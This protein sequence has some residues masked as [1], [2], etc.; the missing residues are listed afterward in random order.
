MLIGKVGN[1]PV[2]NSPAD[3]CWTHTFVSLGQIE[4]CNS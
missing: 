3:E 1:S 4:K 2:G